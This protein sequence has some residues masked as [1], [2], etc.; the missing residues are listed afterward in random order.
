MG[1]N[2]SMSEFGDRRGEKRMFA[3]ILDD[4]RLTVNSQGAILD[5]TQL[6]RSDF[7]AV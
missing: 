3:E 2:L 1:S 4:T 5:I 7:G 6:L